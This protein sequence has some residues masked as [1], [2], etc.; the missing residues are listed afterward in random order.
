[1]IMRHK[2]SK[3]MIFQ[4]LIFSIE[5]PAQ[6]FVYKSEK[7]L[8]INFEEAIRYLFQKHFE[9]LILQMIMIC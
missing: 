8:N 2:F 5:K 1:M 3:F 6:C 7:S 4:F 9:L